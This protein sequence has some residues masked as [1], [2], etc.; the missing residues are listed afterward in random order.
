MN[1]SENGSNAE[2]SAVLEPV[3]SS[4]G[5]YRLNLSDYFAP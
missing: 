1:R 3:H 5:E 2:I 4:A